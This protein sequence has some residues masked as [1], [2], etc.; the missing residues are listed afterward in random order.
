MI[1]W[2]WFSPGPPVSSTIKTDR[3]D[4]WNIVE[5]AQKKT[6]TH[7]HDS[8]IYLRSTIEDKLNLCYKGHTSSNVIKK[9]L[10][11]FYCYETLVLS[12]L[13]ACFDNE[14]FIEK[15]RLVCFAK[16]FLNQIELTQ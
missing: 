9:N 10:S 15:E 13:L 1:K 7:D 14:S 11:F 8:F 12:F 5:S 3:H 4:K 6:T 16:T 2:L